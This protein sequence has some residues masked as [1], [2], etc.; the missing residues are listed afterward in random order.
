MEIH[1]GYIVHKIYIFSTYSF[2]AF[3]L[4]HLQKNKKYLSKK[5]NLKHFQFLPKFVVIKSH[6]LAFKVTSKYN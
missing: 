3:I 1:E 4:L 2:V 6:A 5:C